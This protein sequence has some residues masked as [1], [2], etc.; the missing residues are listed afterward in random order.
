M[1]AVYILKWDFDDSSQLRN[2]VLNYLKDYNNDTY[3]YLKAASAP[4]LFDLKTI[5]TLIVAYNKKDVYIQIY[6]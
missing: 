1:P 2:S 5:F 4:D 6:I 3:F